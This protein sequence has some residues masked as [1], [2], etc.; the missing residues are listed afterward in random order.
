MY[1]SETKFLSASDIK[2]YAFSAALASSILFG[3]GHHGTVDA[4]IVT[5]VWMF[6]LFS[7]VVM[8][9][10]SV[11]TFAIR[12]HDKRDDK[13][14][15]KFYKAL[16]DM[17]KS[18]AKRLVGFMFI[19]YWLYALVVQEWTVTAVFYVI[20]TIYVQVF[21]FLTKDIAKE[22]FVSQLKGE[23]LDE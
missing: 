16:S 13:D 11:A 3:Y 23:G 10:L 14:L 4:I 8:I 21:I 5:V 15:G 17:H 9:G 18:N 7:A 2:G 20:L 1:K 12:K 6:L 19:G 22:F